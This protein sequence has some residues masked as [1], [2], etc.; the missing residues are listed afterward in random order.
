VNPSTFSLDESSALERDR[1]D[2]LASFRSRFAI[3]QRDGR[4]VAYFA[5][6]SLGLMPH[7]ARENVERELEEWKT[8]ALDAHFDAEYP[9]YSYHEIFRESGARLVG[10]KPGEVVMMNGLTVNLNL[11]LIS[12]YRPKPDRYKIVTEPNCFPS[13]LYALQAQVRNHGFNPADAI[14]TLPVSNGEYLVQMEDALAYIEEHGRET[15]LVHI[16]GVDYL[17]GQLFDIAAIT[18]VA[19]ER[20]CVVGVDLAHAAGNVPLRMHDWGVD[21]AVWCSYKY[22]NSGP[23][24]IAGCFVHERHG[25]D[26]SLPRLAGWWGNDPDTRFEMDTTRD[27]VPRDGAEG[28]QVSNPPIFAMA[29]LK[30]SLKIFDEAGIDALRKKSVE[31]TGYLEF[32]VK[33][34]AGDAIELITPSDPEQRG[35]QLSLRARERAREFLDVLSAAGIV[36]D[37]RPPDVIRAAPVPLYNTFHDVWRFGQALKRAVG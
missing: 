2:V 19:H 20:G 3:P 36:P 15:A 4:E 1:C 8:L 34:Y 16:G 26:A 13:D 21:Y 33:E 29:P 11:M 37:F 25:K 31:L 14:I 12:F 28:W 10:A 9:W 23:G 22:L 17:T 27:F 6:N 5:G 35:C 24:S 7:S 32:L 18:R 30:G